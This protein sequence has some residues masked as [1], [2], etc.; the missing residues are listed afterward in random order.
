VAEIAAKTKTPL[1]EKF[2]QLQDIAD[3]KKPAKSK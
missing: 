1:A 3:R 2:Q